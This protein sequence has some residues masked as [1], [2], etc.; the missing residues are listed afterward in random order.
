ML[1]GRKL[2]R[3][4]KL[5]AEKGK[6]KTEYSFIELYLSIVERFHTDEGPQELAV[7]IRHPLQTW[8]RAWAFHDKA[9]IPLVGLDL[10]VDAEVKGE[11]T[12]V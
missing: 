7:I 11:N 12:P 1:P 4:I 2:I 10:G 3:S 5:G 6:E 9:V 8:F